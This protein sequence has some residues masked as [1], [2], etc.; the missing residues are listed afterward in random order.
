MDNTKGTET[1][2]FEVYNKKRERVK[3]PVK[4]AQFLR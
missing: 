4:I 1:M 2:A 3:S